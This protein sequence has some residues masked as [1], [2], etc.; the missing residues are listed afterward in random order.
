MFFRRKE[1][2]WEVVDSRSVDP[3][4]MYYDNDNEDFELVS[5]KDT[6]VRRKYVLEVKR[7]MVGRSELPK[8]LV[9]ARGQLLQEVNKN[10]YNILLNESWRVTL[11]RKA[12]LH[13]VE[14]EYSGRPALVLNEPLVQH[15]PFLAVLAS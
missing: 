15:P 4:S 5:V 6:K 8:A 14:I 7:D 1:I 2:P 9:F 11:L 3:V 13:R 12:K 10:G